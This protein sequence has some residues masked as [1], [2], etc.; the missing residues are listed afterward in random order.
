MYFNDSLLSK[1]FEAKEGEQYIRHDL[2]IWESDFERRAK[3]RD[4]DG[5]LMLGD[6]ILDEW[7][8]RTS[9]GVAQMRAYYDVIPDK[10]S[11]LT[12]SSTNRNPWGDPLPVIRFRDSEWTRNLLDDTKAKIGERFDAIVAAGGGKRIATREYTTHDHPAGGCRMGEDPAT[13]VVD[14]FGRT[15]DHENLWVVGTPTLVSSGCNNGTL[16]FSALA[17]RSAAALADQI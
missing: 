11:S 3:L 1:R 15:H 10:E 17:L 4:A 6:A 14:P 8:A 12:L 5:E 16:T 13:S 9:K 2:R 7:R